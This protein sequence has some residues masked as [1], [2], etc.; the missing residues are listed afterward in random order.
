[1]AKLV[2]YDLKEKSKH[3]QN[4]LEMFAIFVD[5]SPEVVVRLSLMHLIVH[6]AEPVSQHSVSRDHFSLL[7]TSHK[8][9]SLKMTSVPTSP[10]H[11]LEKGHTGNT[12][13]RFNYISHSPVLGSYILQEVQKLFG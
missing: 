13:F 2:A 9:K 11:L 4:L 3:S 6:V 12:W 1:M 5:I 8:D 7:I 10:S